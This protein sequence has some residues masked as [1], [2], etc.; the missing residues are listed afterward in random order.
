MYASPPPYYYDGLMGPP[1]TYMRR[2]AR[3]YERV[4]PRFPRYVAG[5]GPSVIAD[6]SPPVPFGSSA[7]AVPPMSMMIGNNMMQPSPMAQSP[8]FP[9]PSLPMPA[10]PPPSQQTSPLMPQAMPSPTVLSAPMPQPSFTT[11]PS[12]GMPQMVPPSDPALPTKQRSLTVEI[13][14]PPASPPS[15]YVAYSFSTLANLSEPVRN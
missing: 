6:M 8:Q 2:R 14:T 5:Y 1:L 12:L 4:P 3:S 10:L 11:L 13:Q 9:P 7:E 15:S